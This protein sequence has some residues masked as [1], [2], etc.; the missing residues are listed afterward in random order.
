MISC[1][2]REYIWQPTKWINFS[3]SCLQMVTIILHGLVEC[4]SKQRILHEC[5]CI[6]EFIKPVGE[7]D[8]MRGFAEHLISFPQRV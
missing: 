6:I 7:K 3:E 5:S 8:Q 4:G 2:G 1:S